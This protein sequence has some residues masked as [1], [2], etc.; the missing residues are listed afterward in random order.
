M[1]I[2][3]LVCRRR[4]KQRDQIGYIYKVTN[5]YSPFRNKGEP[6]NYLMYH[7]CWIET[8]CKNY[9]YEEGDIEIV[10]EA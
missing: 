6:A 3:D 7:V 1:K 4:S 8:E 9:C 10:S 2:G 5:H